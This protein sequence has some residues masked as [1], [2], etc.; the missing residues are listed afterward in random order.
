MSKN[1]SSFGRGCVDRWTGIPLNQ[2]ICG[3]CEKQHWPVCY[4]SPLCV[5]LAAKTHNEEHTPGKVHDRGALLYPELAIVTAPVL[6]G[7]TIILWPRHAGPH[8]ALAKAISNISIHVILSLSPSLIASKP[9]V[10]WSC[11]HLE[12]VGHTP[13]HPNVP[14]TSV[15]T[16][17]AGACRYG[18]MFTPFH[19]S[20]DVCHYRMSEQIEELG[21][22]WWW[23]CQVPIS[24]LNRCCMNVFQFSFHA[25]LSVQPPMYLTP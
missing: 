3:Y 25:R 13:S 14:D 23:A 11:I 6:S 20:M 24:T 15:Q 2:G 21:Q 16:S 9:L 17:V 1:I 12:N 22:T 5:L 8:T 18:I 10:H 7:R 19:S 4:W